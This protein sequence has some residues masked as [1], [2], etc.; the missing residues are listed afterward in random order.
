MWE[1]ILGGGLA[2]SL[3][4]TI[5]KFAEFLISRYGKKKSTTEIA[6]RALLRE[7]IRYLCKV[8]IAAGEIS[9][10][11]RGDLISMHDVYHNELGGN[12]NLDAEMDEVM[13]L[14]CR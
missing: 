14:K 4:I 9:Y 12:G 3:I 1:T 5:E 8:H 6:L 11:D 13:K 2:A 10:T 7:R